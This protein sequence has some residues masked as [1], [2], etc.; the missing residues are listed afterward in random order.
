MYHS[1]L[2]YDVLWYNILRCIVACAVLI[3]IVLLRA[4]RLVGR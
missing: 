4:R 3:G 1:I 2:F